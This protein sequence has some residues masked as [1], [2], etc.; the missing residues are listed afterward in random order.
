M[1]RIEGRNRSRTYAARTQPEA[2][3][4]AGVRKSLS[5]MM[6]LG[7]VEPPTSRLSDPRR[8]SASASSTEKVR[9]LPSARHQTAG[10]QIIPFS[11]THDV[12]SADRLAAGFE[13]RTREGRNPVARG[14]ARVGGQDRAQDGGQSLT[15]S[16]TVVRVAHWLSKLLTCGLTEW[17]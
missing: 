10:T 2:G 9:P 15:T 1:T 8:E 12:R 16:A 6:G 14:S 3:A 7:G 5:C 4:Y 13:S 11:R 17:L